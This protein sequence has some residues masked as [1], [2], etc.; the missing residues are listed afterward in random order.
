M[1]KVEVISESFKVKFADGETKEFIKTDEIEYQWST[2][3]CGSLFIYKKTLHAMFSSAVIKDQRLGCYARGIWEEVEV[4]E[5]GSVPVLEAPK[6][7]E[8]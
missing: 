2:A 6:D 3:P 8:A 7:Y 5:E 4:L 1:S